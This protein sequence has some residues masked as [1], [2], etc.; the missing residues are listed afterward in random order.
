MS[1][2]KLE[3]YLCSTGLVA[4]EDIAQALTTMLQVNKT[5]LGGKENKN[6]NSQKMLHTCNCEDATFHIGYIGHNRADEK[7][8]RKDR[9]YII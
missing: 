9:S 4:T 2:R 1:E 5:H 8:I 3:I 7:C 6:I